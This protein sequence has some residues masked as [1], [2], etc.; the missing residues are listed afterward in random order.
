HYKTGPLYT[1]PS[2]VTDDNWGTL[3]VPE[4]QGGAN[5]PGGSV[6]PVNNLFYVYSKSNVQ[7]FGVQLNA[8][9][10]LTSA[11]GGI[12]RGNN[13]NIGGAFGGRAD[14]GGRAGNGGPVAE[15]TKDGL[16]DPIVQRL[17]TV[18]GMPILR[19]PWGR[20]TALNLNDGTK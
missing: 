14:P 19:P 6:D 17:L 5:W 11:F 18:G 1:P 2:M 8:D 16:D 20:I 3:A 4:S 13:D 15:D 7:A 12:A 9:G 10:E